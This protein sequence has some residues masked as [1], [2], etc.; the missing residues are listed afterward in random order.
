MAGLLLAEGSPGIFS[1]LL[2][3][4]G[5]M[6][7]AVI[8]RG[9]AVSVLVV[10]RDFGG[11]VPMVSTWAWVWGPLGPITLNVEGVVADAIQKVAPWG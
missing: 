11:N 4:S 7:E 6:P 2:R 9:G 5:Q 3:W 10:Q 1:P 8:Q